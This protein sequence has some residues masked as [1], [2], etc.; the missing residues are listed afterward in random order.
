MFEGKIQWKRSDRSKLVVDG[1]D[2]N[3]IIQGGLG[4]CYFLSSLSILAEH[5]KRMEKIFAT[6][7]IVNGVFAAKIFLDGIPTTY[8]KK[9]KKKFYLP[10]NFHL[11]P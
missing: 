7:E 1:V 9:K 6:P 8:S 11:P 3:D 4:D 2:P 5:P 10:N